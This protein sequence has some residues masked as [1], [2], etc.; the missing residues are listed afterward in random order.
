[1]SNQSRPLLTIGMNAT[2]VM[3]AC[4]FMSPTGGVPAAGGDTLGV[5]RMPVLNIGERVPVDT[6]GTAP[7]EIGAAIT[8]GQEIDVDASGRAVPHAAG[9]Q[10]GKALE[11][12]TSVGDVVEVLLYCN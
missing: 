6:A 7:V 9:K 12:A 4:R 5:T 8:A 1:M 10:R 11:S 3:P 2:A